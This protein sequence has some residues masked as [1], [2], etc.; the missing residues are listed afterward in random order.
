MADE[1]SATGTAANKDAGRRKLPLT[2]A[3][4]VVVALLFQA[5]TIAY[6]N[7]SMWRLSFMAIEWCV[8]LLGSSCANLVRD[9]ERRSEDWAASYVPTREGWLYR[10]LSVLPAATVRGA[11]IAAFLSI[12]NATVMPTM[13]YRETIG[14]PVV[15]V[16]VRF[17]ADVPTAIV[18]CVAVRL[19]VD[20]HFAKVAAR[21]A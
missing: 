17:L 2:I 15:A 13:I 1:T 20:R 6:N 14:N 9:M 16:I 4:A 3:S 7:Y 12:P 19:V 21:Q 18:I 11:I 10:L 8:A 5:K